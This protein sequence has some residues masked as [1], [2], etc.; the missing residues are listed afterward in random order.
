MKDK[1]TYIVAI[2]VVLMVTIYFNGKNKDLK[3]QITHLNNVSDISIQKAIVD[4]NKRV[5]DS[6]VVE[7]KKKPANTIIKKQIKYKYEKI[8][9]S[10][11]LLPNGRKWKYITDRLNVRYPD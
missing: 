9:D 5:T 4:E 2:L 10:I 6:L 1:L 3:A 7:F 11:F 8:I